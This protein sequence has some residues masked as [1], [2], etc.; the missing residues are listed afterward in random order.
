VARNLTTGASMH[1][2][3]N[4]ALTS[5]PWLDGR[6]AWLA[7]STRNGT[8]LVAFE[9]SPFAF[10]DRPDLSIT[11]P[12]SGARWTSVANV[13]GV[14]RLPG[15][16]AQPTTFTYRVDDLPPVAIPVAERFR[17]QVDP[18]DFEPGRHQVVVRATFREGPPVEANILLLLPT[19]ADERIDVEQLGQTY[20]AARVAFTVRQYVTENPASFLLVAL[21]LL[22]L[23][24]LALRVWVW[25][26]PARRRIEVEYVPPE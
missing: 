25:L 22:L 1:V 14:F 4:L 21:V 16:W 24:V 10:A 11:S 7:V 13:Q 9:V 3:G 2:T 19:V 6:T 15:D 5:E 8:S 12:R 26:R 18:Q 17:F 20:H 23:V